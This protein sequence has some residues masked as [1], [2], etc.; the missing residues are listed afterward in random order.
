M[1]L[2]KFYNDIYNVLQRKAFIQSLNG[3]HTQVVQNIGIKE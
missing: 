1:Q 2:M 3:D